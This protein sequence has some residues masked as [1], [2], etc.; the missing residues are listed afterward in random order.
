MSTL[1]I[2]V[3]TVLICMIAL[4]YLVTYKG[5]VI[6]A[7]LAEKRRRLDEAYGEKRSSA[8]KTPPER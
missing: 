4:G 3:V 1:S 5:D 6:D 7:W 8:G 2:V